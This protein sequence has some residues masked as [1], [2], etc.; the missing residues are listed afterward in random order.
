MTDPE[1]DASYWSRS[2]ADVATDLGSGPG[3]LTS[4]RAAAQLAAVGPNSVE[5]PRV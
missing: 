4:E 1:R 3:G 5:T 2:A